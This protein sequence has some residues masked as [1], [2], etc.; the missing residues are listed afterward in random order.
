MRVSIICLLLPILAAC[1]VVLEPEN[2]HAVDAVT[3]LP[4]Q[5]R[6]NEMVVAVRS[7]ANAM[8]D[9]PN[10]ISTDDRIAVGTFGRIDSL[11][12]DGND[13][14]A[15][16]TLSL[17]IQEGLKAQLA[18]RN[19]NVVEYRL[20]NTIAIKA[21]QDVMLSRE[22]SKVQQ[23]HDI[24]Y[25]LTGT[26]TEQPNGVIVN[27]QLVDVE[28]KRIIT[29][30]TQTLSAHYWNGAATSTVSNHMIYRSEK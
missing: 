29:A 22:L 9:V 4:E 11:N 23:H 19:I 16:R 28:S 12:L 7:L 20:R 26:L 24:D 21:E 25:F 30:A 14:V 13:S 27:A 15:F 1:T 5:P 17:Q 8:F 10:L 6:D 3:V 2:K 18:R